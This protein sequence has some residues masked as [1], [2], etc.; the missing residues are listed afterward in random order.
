MVRVELTDSPGVNEGKVESGCSIA[1][2]NYK[3]QKSMV[4]EYMLVE[5]GIGSGSVYRISEEQTSIFETVY[6][7]ALAITAAKTA[8]EVAV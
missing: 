8:K 4:E 6:E 5:T 1:F 7:C 2:D 3:P